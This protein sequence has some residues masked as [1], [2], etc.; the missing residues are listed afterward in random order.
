MLA[1]LD[2]AVSRLFGDE[3][4]LR[5]HEPVPV[6]AHGQHTSSRDAPTGLLR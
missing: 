1:A 3:I 2:N 5:D 6:H 4:Q